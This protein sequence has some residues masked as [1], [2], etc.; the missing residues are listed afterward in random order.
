MKK[1]YSK[2]TRER[3]PRFQI[4]TAIYRDQDGRKYAKKHPLTSVCEA[5]MKRIYE[6]YKL[7][8]NQGLGLFAQCEREG[9]SIVFPFINGKSY[10]EYLLE[11]V[12]RGDR[13]GFYMN[14]TAYQKNVEQMY[15]QCEPF[16]ADELFEDIFGVVQG[17]EGVLAARKLDI[18]LTFDNVIIQDANQV[19]IIDYEWM[20]DCLVPVKFAYYRAIKAFY[21]KNSILLDGFLP[22][23]E[24]YGFFDIKEEELPV[25]ETM[26][27][28]FMDYVNG[29]EKSYEKILEAYKVPAASLSNDLDAS[30]KQALLFINCGEGYSTD[31]CLLTQMPDENR[32]VRM[33]IDLSTYNNVQEIR[34]DPVDVSAAIRIRKFF[35]KRQG[36]EVQLKMEDVRH[37]GMRG[38]DGIWIFDNNDPQILIA[39]TAE[40]MPER[41]FFEFEVLFTNFEKYESYVNP[42][43]ERMQVA[44]QSEERLR[45]LIEEQ[46][47]D[48]ANRHRRIEELTAENNIRKD[49]LA[50]I[51]NT[52][53]FQMFLKKKVDAINIWD[54]IR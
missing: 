42:Y 3:D 21:L 10:F 8:S 23:I 5:H 30:L 2:F 6:N 47:I 4:E 41:V 11:D 44:V 32:V 51:E 49:K 24:V 31:T 48:I 33:D 52:R 37:N 14:L 25:Y 36:V 43:K 13:E 7:F 1:I 39:V 18:D 22:E 50:Y 28:H 29:K 46:K 9:K 54:A 40:T 34:I 17:Q 20:F 35:V 15:P 38:Q 19:H 26:N 53:A 27:Q 16:V 45:H 12:K